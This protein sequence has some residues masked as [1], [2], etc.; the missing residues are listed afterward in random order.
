[1]A[2]VHWLSIWPGSPTPGRMGWCSRPRRVGICAAP[3]SAVAG[4]SEQPARP[5]WR[6]YGSRPASLGGHPGVGG[7]GEHAGADG[8][9][10]PHL[11]TGGIALPACD[12]RPRPGHRR[13]FGRAGPGRR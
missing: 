3:T 7:R 8:A 9:R 4:G 11:S 5:G 1:V 6:G 12:G 10:G 13:R 2:A